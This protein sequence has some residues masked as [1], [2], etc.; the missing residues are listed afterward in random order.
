[1]K[2]ALLTILVCTSILS[3]KS[4]AQSYTFSKRTET[5]A[6]ISGG[7]SITN[8]ISLGFDVTIAG[9]KSSTLK[10]DAYFGQVGTA[11]PLQFSGFY[12]E[13]QDGSKTYLV[14]GNAG[15]RIVKVQYDKVKFSHNAWGSDYATFQIWIYEKDNAIELHMGPSSVSNPTLAYYYN[16]PKGPGIGF[17]KMWL[18]GSPSAPTV[19][20]ATTYLTGTPASGQV[21]RFAPPTTSIGTAAQKGSANISL[22]PNPG[23][24][25]VNISATASLE[26]SHLTV[27]SA[28]GKVVLEQNIQNATTSVDISKLA[29]GIYSF[30]V[31][32]KDGTT[33]TKT[34]IKQ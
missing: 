9:V 3:M 5:Y 24:G 30:N 11:T 22:Y 21:Y 31:S 23:N 6:P 17:E 28:D 8:N 14:T 13:I 20:T 34:Y 27:Y 32:K 2:K 7:T 15:D 10:T 4:V 25:K 19:D 29:N 12:A 26:G 18:S 33:V 16:T 1:M